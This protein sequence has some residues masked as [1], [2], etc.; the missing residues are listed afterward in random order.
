MRT[1]GKFRI[2]WY[3][4]GREP[5]HPANP[6]YPSGV[7][8]DISQ[9]AENTCTAALPYPAKR[10]GFYA[11]ECM[12]CGYTVGVS[13]AGRRDDPRSLTIACRVKPV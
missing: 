8:M 4:S 10:C 13:T 12:I 9:G 5:Q 2:E 11:V 7:D 6:A 3:D 1:A